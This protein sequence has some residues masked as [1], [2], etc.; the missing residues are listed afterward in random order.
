MISTWSVL[1][2]SLI[3]DIISY[4]LFYNLAKIMI[5]YHHSELEKTKLYYQSF[6]NKQLSNLSDTK[7]D[8]FNQTLDLYNA[9]NKKLSETIL[10]QNEQF[11]KLYTKI[12]DNK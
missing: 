7:D 5:A 2:V 10:K 12:L 8:F 9:E 1:A 6:Y 3:I 11:E 4:I